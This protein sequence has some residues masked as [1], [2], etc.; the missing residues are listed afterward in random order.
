M[1][2]RAQKSPPAKAGYSR[3]PCCSEERNQFVVSESRRRL[4]A[5][6]ASTEAVP[7]T[8]VTLPIESGGRNGKGGGESVSWRST[9]STRY[10]WDAVALSC[11]TW[12]AKY[13]A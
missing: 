2:A 13:S 8:P 10:H 4:N 3:R 11:W 1:A 6:I 9:N 5:V 12:P 7:Q